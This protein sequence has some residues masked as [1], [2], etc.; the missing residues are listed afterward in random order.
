MRKEVGALLVREMSFA[1]G[2]SIDF[3]TITDYLALV[4][5]LSVRLGFS[6]REVYRATDTF[7]ALSDELRAR[8]HL[9]VFD[10]IVHTDNRSKV[11][12]IDAWVRS[13]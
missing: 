1:P 3:R 8:V 12:K 11:R 13:T 6:K 4:A 10:Q 5:Y 9:S 7:S 2:L